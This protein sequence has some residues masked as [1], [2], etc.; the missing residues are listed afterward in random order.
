M[1][2]QSNQHNQLNQDAKNQKKRIPVYILIIV[3]IF[4]AAC[5]F[6]MLAD[7]NPDQTVNPAI[8]ATQD[9]GQTATAADETA[10]ENPAEPVADT[11]TAVAQ[12]R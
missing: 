1:V 2:D 11:A 4:L 8:P 6:Y 7:R 9:Q 3:G 10:V 5:I 12:D